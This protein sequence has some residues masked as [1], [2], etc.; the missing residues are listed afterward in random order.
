MA[1]SV[2]DLRD[3]RRD[4]PDERAELERMLS[5]S[6]FERMWINQEIA[7]SS[8]PMI[9]YG[10]VEVS[11]IR[12]AA[13]LLRILPLS[14]KNPDQADPLCYMPGYINLVIMENIRRQVDDVDY[15]KPNDMLKVARCFKASLPVDRVYAL[16]G[17][18]EEQ[19][20]PL[21][22]PNYSKDAAGDS[23]VLTVEQIAKDAISTLRT[24]SECYGALSGESPTVRGSAMMA[25]PTKAVRRLKLIMRDA[26]R[27]TQSLDRV[28][29][30]KKGKRAPAQMLTD[31]SKHTTPEMVYTAVAREMVQQGEF[32]LLF[33]HAGIGI[34]RN[35]EFKTLPSWVPDWS[36]ELEARLLPHPSPPLKR[37]QDE[38]D[39]QET[40]PA[41]DGIN[42]V[43][44]DMGPHILHL[45]GTH[46][47][48]IAH[49]APLTPLL[50]KEH[51]SETAT[52]QAR[53]DFRNLQSNWAAALNLAR[54]QCAQYS[55][56]YPTPESIVHTFLRT[57]LANTSTSASTSTSTRQPATTN[58]IQ[59]G[60]A[61]MNGTSPTCPIKSVLE[62]TKRHPTTPLTESQ[63]QTI[64]KY[65][66]I[67]QT[68]SS[69]NTRLGHLI[70]NDVGPS[71]NSYSF[72]GSRKKSVLTGI[73]SIDDQWAAERK[74]PGKRLLSVFDT[75]S[76]FANPLGTYEAFVE[77]TIG[78]KRAVHL[79]RGEDDDDDEEE[80][81]CEDEDG[82]LEGVNVEGEEEDGGEED[83][84]KT[85]DMCRL[86]GEAYVHDAEWDGRGE[87]MWFAL[88]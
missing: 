83:G 11:W 65:P 66:F 78:R 25:N 38:E 15:L 68:Q 22:R 48:K 45:K 47:S 57:T 46:I 76:G 26:A 39:Y 43:V 33:S 17:I 32:H 60:L 54:T 28:T 77:Y 4:H 41:T 37:Q 86:G 85:E 49:L 59:A 64:D 79:E 52:K 36:T 40:K 69:P 21:F 34:D 14:S 61:W 35:P 1:T 63:A 72:S 80:E 71:F 75:H 7:T 2:S 10:D 88:W 20:V 9:R 56:Y 51:A 19:Q 30:G 31:Y 73:K 13:A 44:R 23:G 55:R 24:L 8:D 42:L 6:W 62:S 27:L 81:E 3:L 58:D 53:R 16:L 87:E 82:G 84:V 74:E 5:N 18:T 50:T 70:I 29:K 67:R 12:F